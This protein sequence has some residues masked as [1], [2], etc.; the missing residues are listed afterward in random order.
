M[1]EQQRI[2]SGQ[3]EDDGMFPFCEGKKVVSDFV[4]GLWD[5]VSLNRAA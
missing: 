5:T 4:L 1:E 3:G 2:V